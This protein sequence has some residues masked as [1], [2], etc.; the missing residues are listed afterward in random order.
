VSVGH[1]KA[2]SIHCL[3]LEI[4]F[5]QYRRLVAN[6]PP[7]MPGFDGH[8]FRRAVFF[9]AA[10]L[11]L[12]IDLAVGHEADMRVHA[13]FRADLL[14]KLVGPVEAHRVDHALD[15]DG[16]GAVDIYLYTADVASVAIFHGGEDGI[17]EAILP[18]PDAHPG[19]HAF[20]RLDDQRATH[21]RVQ[22]IELLIIN[23]DA[24]FRT[25]GQAQDEERFGIHAQP[26]GLG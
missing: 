14:T 19:V 6:H 3:A 26:R 23:L 1:R 9:H 15:A 21:V 11:K 8:K 7:F 25:R 22:E 2:D 4:E 18:S 5:D 16:P 17:H 13:V 24:I 10:I 20:R 12:D